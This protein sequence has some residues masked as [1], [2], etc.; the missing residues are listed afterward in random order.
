ERFLTAGNVFPA[1]GYGGMSLTIGD[2]PTRHNYT[3]ALLQSKFEPI[4]AGWIAELGVPTL[5]GSEVVGFAQDDTGVDVEVSDGTS[6]RAEYLVGCDGGRSLIRKTAGIEFRGLDPST[7]F[8]IAEVQMAER[9]QIG[10]RRDGG[11]I[12]SVT[13]EATGGLFGVVLKEKDLEY[14]GDPTLQD[15]RE[16]LVLTYGT[17]FGAHSPSWISRFT[18]ASR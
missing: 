5:R 16:A 10:M 18:D 9:P 3:L 13:P 1:V 7:S 6:L 15:L 4:L 14:T 8:I 12:G 11:G 2:F 17:D